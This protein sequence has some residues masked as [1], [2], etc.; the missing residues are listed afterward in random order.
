M[1]QEFFAIMNQLVSTLDEL[2]NIINRTY[3]TLQYIPS[4]YR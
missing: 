1:S 3:L 4:L 2:T